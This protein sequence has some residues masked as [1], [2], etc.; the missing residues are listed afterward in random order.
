MDL[1]KTVLRQSAIRLGLLLLMTVTGLVGCSDAPPIQLLYDRSA[2][3]LTL[4]VFPSDRYKGEAVLDGFSEVQLA[5]LPFLRQL[6]FTA[7]TGWAPT[8]AIRI[9]F[10]RS[11]S[12]SS[13]WLDMTTVPAGLR[14]YRVDTNPAT[15]ITPGEMHFDGGSGA[16][17]IRGETPWA[18][19]RYA[20]A[21]LANTLKTRA[22][23]A[24]AASTDTLLTRG[25]G[26]PGTDAD[27]A[28]VS[29]VDPKISRRS[30]TLALFSFTVVDPTAQTGYLNVVITGKAPASLGDADEMMALSPFMPLE[31]RKLAIVGQPVATDDAAIDAVF[32]GAGLGALPR[33]AIGR[34]TGGLVVTP[35]FISDPVPDPAAL[36]TNHTI[37]GR[38]GLLPFSPANPPVLSARAPYRELPFIAFFPKVALPN[39]PIIVALHP[40]DSQKEAFFAFAHAACAAGHALIAIDLYQ[41][42]A[43]QADIA[44]PEGDFA[45]RVDVV[46]KGAGIIFPDPFFNLTFL[47]RTRDRFR[48]SLADT[49]SLIH[50]LTHANGADP[51]VDID[52]DG[53]PD[54]F[55]AIRIVGHSFGALIGAVAAAISPAVD[56]VVL[57]APCADLIQCLD[58]SPA[59]ATRLGLLLLAT[60]NANQIGLMAGS[61]RR[62]VPKTPQRD[63]FSRVAETI[64]APVD[65][66]SWATTLVGRQST[67]TPLRMLIQ[68]PAKDLVFTPN[69]NR[70]FADAIGGAAEAGEVAY[71]QLGDDLFNL[72]WPPIVD[73]TKGLPAITAATIA[74]GHGFFLD[75][76]DP[77]V[78][79][80]AQQQAAGFLASP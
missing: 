39:T 79:G 25:Q 18:P 46:L 6:R 52:A 34:I 56:R 60:G 57:A 4:T 8:T 77:A 75:F 10:T 27:L 44:V 55:G 33:A 36:F 50:I 42:G 74:G 73:P 23:D 28:L 9:P 70:R 19:G 32:V 65:P 58:E 64:L 43:R 62:M 71:G 80:A 63:V 1:R 13:R 2:E 45:E 53:T 30:D 59:L 20:V 69:G 11:R 21:V 61:E 37:L 78:T 66:A 22:G 72:G 67:A 3:D 17:L 7:Q 26:D 5:S 68:M 15:P 14:I 49:L 31:G 16:L 54:T 38:G 24:I 48:Q 41:Q 29:A 12:D 51:R 47:A 40:L 35:N 76:V